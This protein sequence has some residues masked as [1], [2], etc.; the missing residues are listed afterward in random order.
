M[1]TNNDGVPSNN[2][3]DGPSNNSDGVQPSKNEGATATRSERILMAH[4]GGGELTARLIEEQILA[5]L[6][7]ETLDPLMDAAV[8]PTFTGRVCMTTDSFVVQPLEFPGGDIGTLAVCG[9]VNDLAVMGAIPRGLSL[10][11][12]IEEGF[13]LDRLGRI[14]DSL[15]ATARAAGVSIVTGDTKVVEYGR[16]DGLLINTTGVGEERPGLRLGYEGMVAGDAVIVT[17]AIAEHG[18]AV[19]SAREGLSF[20]TTL[21]SDVAPLNGLIDTVLATGADI[22]FMRDPTRGGLAGVLNDVA[23]GSRLSVELH[24]AAIPLTAVVRHTSEMLGLDPLTVANEG[25]VVIVVAPK[26][27]DA[28]LQACHEHQHGRH[29][30]VIGHLTAA[31]PPLVELTTRIGGQR[32]VQRP[33]GEDLPRI[34]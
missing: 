16:G 19:M 21:L 11:L 5:R 8:L 17:G 13:E 27:A 7:N 34:C 25:K 29:A 33:Y 14:L 18:L 2:S 3:N 9:T 26:D 24:E 22:R 23:E 30:A 1:T 15:A 4:G 28:V 10:A 31:T 12:I 20:D 6:A 32:V